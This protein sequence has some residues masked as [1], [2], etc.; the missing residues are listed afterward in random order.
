[1]VRIHWLKEV[2]VCMVLMVAH[3]HLQTCLTRPG[4][5]QDLPEVEVQL[6]VEQ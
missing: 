5:G 6:Q 2:K 3:I 4:G 1:M